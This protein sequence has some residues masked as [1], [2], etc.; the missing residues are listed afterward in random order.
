MFP[1]YIPPILQET[2]FQKS[3][4]ERKH[5]TI[6]NYEILLNIAGTIYDDNSF[7]LGRDDPIMI[8]TNR[9]YSP[10]FNRLSP[11][12]IEINL[13]SE[14]NIEIMSTGTTRFAWTIQ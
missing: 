7:N 11:A 9:N 3:I 2:G 4:K 10:L 1:K 12:L 5:H 6:G 8:H 14:K 13:Y